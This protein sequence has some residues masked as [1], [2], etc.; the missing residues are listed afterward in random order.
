MHEVTDL[1][2]V[3]GSF[4]PSHYKRLKTTNHVG[5]PCFS[6]H[7][8]PPFWSIMH[9]WDNPKYG[10]LNWE[11]PK[12]MGFTRLKRL[13]DL[14][15]FSDLGVPP[16]FIGNLQPGSFPKST[17]QPRHQSPFASRSEQRRS[18][19]AAQPDLVSHARRQHMAMPWMLASAA[20]RFKVLSN[21]LWWFESLLWKVCP[22][23]Q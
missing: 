16:W 13:N 2:S 14:N 19:H 11:I 12:P 4:N 1:Q 9:S 15:S 17:A 21:T 7:C 18:P 3:S 22:M 8:V 6:W 5:W 10:F 23:Y 20:G